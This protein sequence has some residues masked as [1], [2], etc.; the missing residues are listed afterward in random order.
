MSKFMKISSALS[1]VVDDEAVP[2]KM[3]LEALRQLPHPGLNLLRRLLVEHKPGSKSAQRSKYKK[4]VPRTLRA[5][6]ALRFVQEWRRAQL[7]RARGKS[8]SASNPLGI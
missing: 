3:R 7:R 4:P 6:A 5:L 1:T 8:S 2:A